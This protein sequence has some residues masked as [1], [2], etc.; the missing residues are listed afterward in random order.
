MYFT[1][2]TVNKPDPRQ[3]TCHCSVGAL[4]KA[5][6]VIAVSAYVC[7]EGEMEP[8][9]MAAHDYPVLPRGVL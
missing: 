7:F 8:G 9:I 3:L 1:H 2:L 4:P 6:L 5:V